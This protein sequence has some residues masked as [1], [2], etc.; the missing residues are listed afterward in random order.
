MKNWQR[1]KNLEVFKKLVLNDKA[2]IET[3]NTD[4]TRSLL[5]ISDINRLQDA[6]ALSQGNT[7]YVDSV[8]GSSGYT[9]K[10]QSRAK[11]TIDQAINVAS[12]GDTIIVLAGH[13]ES[14]SAAG[15]IA[16]DVAGLTFVGLGSGSRK[17]QIT[18]DTADTATMTISAANQTFINFDFIAGFADITAMI[19]ITASNVTF[20]DCTFK[21]S[22]TDLNFVDCI[23]IATGLEGFGFYNCRFRGGDAA[24]DSFITCA[25]TVDEVEMKNCSL[26]LNTAQAAVVGLIDSV[27]NA[28]NVDIDN[29]RFRSNVDGALFLD[30]NG[31]ANSGCISNCYFSSI[32]TAGAVTAGFDF[33]GGHIFECY[34][35]GEADSFGLVGGGTVYNNA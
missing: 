2:D 20:A 22:G 18:W 14:I 30:F 13:S 5:S 10:T 4:G 33:T 21:E 34:V 16:V 9:G 17:P 15:G 8:N 26:Y 28:T 23:T 27:G 32:D 12:A 19:P 3:V 6:V 11:A 24:N 31:T 35:A 25:G 1:Y 29:C 7:W